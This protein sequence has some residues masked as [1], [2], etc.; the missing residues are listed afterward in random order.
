MVLATFDTIL[1]F[2]LTAIGGISLAAAGLI[3][4]TAL[5]WDGF[6]DLLIG[7]WADRTGRTDFLK[8]LLTIGAPLC[9]G[10]FA[11]LFYIAGTDPAE[12]VVIVALL[13]WA[14]RIGYTLCDVAHNSMLVNISAN[15]RGASASS[16][17]RLIFSAAGTTAVGLAFKFNLSLPTIEAQRSA[18][19][20]CAALG[21]LAYTL[22]LLAAIRVKDVGLLSRER[23][24]AV[25]FLPALRTLFA[26]VAYRK[27]CFLIVLQAGVTS[28]FMKGLPFLG[29]HFFRGA[30]WAGEAIVAVTVAQVA[31]LPVLIL[32]GRSGVTSRTILLTS[33]ALMAASII[34]L[35]TSTQHLP[36]LAWA[37][38]VGIG[39]AQSGMNM[40]I[41]AKLALVVRERLMVHDG[42]HALPVGLFLAILKCASGF[43]TGIL[44]FGFSWGGSFGVDQKTIVLMVA[45]AAPFASSLACITLSARE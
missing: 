38:L 9:G 18:F 1:F 2:Y 33:H 29:L 27:L 26:T 17:L 44:A 45:M 34:V 4:M 41:W 6:G 24:G 28:L 21:G 37:G 20:A 42:L 10:A 23:A 15:E 39:I 19:G 12:R 43:G 13:C 5:V 3:I 32:L 40:T 8:T 31:A 22:T 7:Y 35:F 14:C 30:A 25:R 11:A 16:G 36:L